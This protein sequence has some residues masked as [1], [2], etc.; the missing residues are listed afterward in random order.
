MLIFADDH[1]L[2]WNLVLVRSWKVM[3]MIFP[4]SVDNMIAKIEQFLLKVTLT[5]VEGHGEEMGHNMLH[6]IS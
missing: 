5:L 3:K 1:G 2:S 4:K 6:I